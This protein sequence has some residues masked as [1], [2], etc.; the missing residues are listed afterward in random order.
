[1]NIN[2]RFFILNLLGLKLLV[3]WVAL[4]VTFTLLIV[5]LISGCFI[6]GLCGIY[7]LI[8]LPFDVDVVPDVIPVLLPFRRNI[9]CV[10]PLVFLGV[11]VVIVFLIMKLRGR[12]A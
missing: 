1:M 6:I 4:E 2:P 11:I 3:V 7:V 8:G 10:I 9:I 5:G 12:K